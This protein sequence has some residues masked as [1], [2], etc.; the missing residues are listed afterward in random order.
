MKFGW[1]REGFVHEI[2]AL[3]ASEL[4]RLA[5]EVAGAAYHRRRVAS[6]PALFEDLRGP[7]EV[8]DQ[9]GQ[10]SHGD[11]EAAGAA[12]VALAVL[13]E[14][15]GAVRDLGWCLGTGEEVGGFREAL[16]QALPADRA[17]SLRSA[18]RLEWRSAVET[19]GR[20]DGLYSAELAAA[21][22]EL[23]VVGTLL[24]TAGSPVGPV[25]CDA[26]AHLLAQL[27]QLDAYLAQWRRMQADRA[28]FGKA[29]AQAA[30]LVWKG[31]RGALREVAP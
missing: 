4:E 12:A 16:L 21:A 13:P 14:L 2:G 10:D 22:R 28:R 24:R 20:C 17:E 8:L 7:V 19:G 30:A 3:R 27:G 18:A 9:A 5:M 1:L 15:W 29:G 6:I 23:R 25:V 11:L 26:A 31:V